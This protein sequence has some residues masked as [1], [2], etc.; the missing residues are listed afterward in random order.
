MNKE[1]PVHYMR[2]AKNVLWELETSA[3][4]ERGFHLGA[5][6][7]LL[8]QFAKEAEE[9]FPPLTMLSVRK[10]KKEY[11]P[12]EAWTKL[13]FDRKLIERAKSVHTGEREDESNFVWNTS[14]EKSESGQTEF[15]RIVVEPTFV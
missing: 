5:D 4:D 6:V 12:N 13:A 10:I 15:I 9:L 8:S 1:T 2:G 14:N 3:E 11:L 7:S